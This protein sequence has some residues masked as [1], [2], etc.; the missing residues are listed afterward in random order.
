MKKNSKII[1]FLVLV[2]V[3]LAGYIAYPHFI[4][5]EPSAGERLDKAIDALSGG[6]DEAAKAI[7]GK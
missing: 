5:K 6:V 2:I 7:E 1:V 4:K 3:G